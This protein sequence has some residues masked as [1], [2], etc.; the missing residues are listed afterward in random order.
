MS[1]NSLSICLIRSKIEVFSLYCLTYTSCLSY[2]LSPSG[3]PWIPK[4]V[5]TSRK[6]Y[7]DIIYMHIENGDSC[8]MT[9]KILWCSRIN[10]REKQS[11]SADRSIKLS[12]SHR[13]QTQTSEVRWAARSSGHW[14]GQHVCISNFQVSIT[15][16]TKEN[17][18][19]K[20]FTT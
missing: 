18:K 16:A 2:I 14:G 9:Y 15:D 1:T 19:R 17:L 6:N 20:T 13:T 4:T 10:K 12:G 11:H 8:Q 5:K 3:L 7:K